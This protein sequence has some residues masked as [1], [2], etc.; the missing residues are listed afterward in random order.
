[1]SE[2]ATLPAA[3]VQPG[4]SHRERRGR[5]Y[6]GAAVFAILLSAAGFLPSMVDQSRRAGTSTLLVAVHGAAA[7]AWIV[8]FLTQAILAASQRMRIHRRLGIAGL[9]IAAAIVV[10]GPLMLIEMR[11]RG[12]D[13]SG[14]ITRITVAPGSP[15]PSREEFAVRMFPVLLSFANFGIL[16]ALGLWFRHRPA[17]HKRLMLLALLALLPTPAFHLGGYLIG[18]WPGLHSAIRAFFRVAPNLVLF[19]G[20]VHDKVSRGRVHP[21]SLWVPILLFVETAGLIRLVMPSD[22]WRRMAIWLVN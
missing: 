4:V 10:T 22:G 12:Y 14:D 16:V 1:M 21:I 18:H 20:A 13:L 17:V 7:G 15:A 5:F 3:A 6:I 19:A 11:Q 2:T 9:F 8:L